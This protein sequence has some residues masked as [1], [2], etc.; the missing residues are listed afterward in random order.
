MEEIVYSNVQAKSCTGECIY[1]CLE[2]NPDSLYT[3][4]SSNC[5]PGC[6]CSTSAP[7]WTSQCNDGGCVPGYDSSCSIPCS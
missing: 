7:E 3:F 1:D 4:R 5:S 2:P 6:S